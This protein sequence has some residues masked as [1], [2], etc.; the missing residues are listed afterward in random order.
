MNVTHSS[1]S[2]LMVTVRSQQGSELLLINPSI[3]KDLINLFILTFL[4]GGQRS[5]CNCT[6]RYSSCDLNV[7]CFIQVRARHPGKL[8]CNA[9]TL[10]LR[11]KITS[12]CRYMFKRIQGTDTHT[13]AHHRCTQLHFLLQSVLQF[14]KCTEISNLLDFTGN[15]LIS[16]FF[17]S[18]LLITTYFTLLL[19]Y[20]PN[21]YSSTQPSVCKTLLRPKI[22][23][24]L[25]WICTTLEFELIRPNQDPVSN[26]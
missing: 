9:N 16:P 2:K 23:Q 10:A 14:N 22:G 4:S 7:S 21:E 19:N 3:S 20:L 12:D 25:K 17:Q 8:S 18:F 6:L 13:P 26:S 1:I 11:A 5:I 15:Q 24:D